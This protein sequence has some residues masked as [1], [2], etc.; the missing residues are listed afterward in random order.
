MEKTI[1]YCNECEKEINKDDENH[2]SIKTTFINS[3]N[4]Y[5][6]FGKGE[7]LDFCNVNCFE[8]Y[9]KNLSDDES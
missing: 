6:S 9:L 3:K 4:R 8:K 7:K 5:K 2:F 1:G